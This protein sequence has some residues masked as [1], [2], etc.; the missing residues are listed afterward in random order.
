V[1]IIGLATYYIKTSLIVDTLYR[2]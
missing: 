2:C 1:F